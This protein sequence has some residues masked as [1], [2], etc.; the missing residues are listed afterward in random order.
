MNP[1]K[2][3]LNSTKL[4]PETIKSTKPI[5]RKKNTNNPN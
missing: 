2:T 4:L 3:L 5:I 1:S